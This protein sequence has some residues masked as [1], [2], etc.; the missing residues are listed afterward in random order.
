M[1]ACD[2]LCPALAGGV[3]VPNILSTATNDLSSTVGSS[4]CLVVTPS[5]IFDHCG[6]GG[7]DLA[8]LVSRGRSSVETRR[9]AVGSIGAAVVHKIAV[10]IGNSSPASALVTTIA[11]IGGLALLAYV[12]DIAIVGID[13]ASVSTVAACRSTA[14][15]A[16]TCVGTGSG[17][18]VD[19]CACV[20]AVATVGS[21]ASV[22]GVVVD[23]DMTTTAADGIKIAPTGEGRGS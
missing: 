12:V 19:T 2:R 6:I 18:T 1:G 10:A 4:R 9:T 14:I 11:K 23:V 8:I 21:K 15:G 13:G 16:H 5:R 17:A 7:V 22:I 20:I 3:T